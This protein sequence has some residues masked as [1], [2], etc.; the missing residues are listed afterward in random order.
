MSTVLTNPPYSHL[1]RTGWRCGP[2]SPQSYPRRT[3]RT[4]PAYWQQLEQGLAIKLFFQNRQICMRNRQNK[5]SGFVKIQYSMN[6]TRNNIREFLNMNN[7]CCKK[8]S[9]LYF[10][11]SSAWQ[12]ISVTIRSNVI[13]IIKDWKESW[14]TVNISIYFY[15]IFEGTLYAIIQNQVTDACL[16]SHI[17]LSLLASCSA[18]FSIRSFGLSGKATSNIS[19]NSSFSIFPSSD[20]SMTLL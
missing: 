8:Q 19:M 20:F 13:G 10:P 1:H 6:S 2:S 9:S 4:R 14:K 12:P 3:R 15:H 11:I 18:S 16:Y 5:V 7:P 17:L